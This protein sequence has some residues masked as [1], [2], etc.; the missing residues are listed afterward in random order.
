MKTT[1]IRLPGRRGDVPG[2][3]EAGGGAELGGGAEVA[4]CPD[5]AAP[6][7]AQPAAARAA[8]TA[9]ATP[10]RIALSLAH[11]D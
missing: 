7:P 11:H 3:L 6:P 10:V 1:T 8:S 4:V 5:D 2:E 9:I